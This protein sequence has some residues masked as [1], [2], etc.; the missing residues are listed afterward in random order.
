MIKE[1]YTNPKTERTKYVIRLSHYGKRFPVLQGMVA[2]ALR[3]F[4]DLQTDDIEIVVYS[5]QR[6]KRTMGIEFWYD[7]APHPDYA[8]IQKLEYTLS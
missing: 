6:Y 7:G 5:G 8:P 3:D 2:E 1:R 4:A